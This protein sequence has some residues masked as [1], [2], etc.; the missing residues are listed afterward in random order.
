[1]SQTSSTRR[2][3]LKHSAVA[4]GTLAALQTSAVRGAYAAADNTIKIALIGCGG[5]GTGAVADCFN[6]AKIL[7]QPIKLVAV[8]DAFQD[9]AVS[10][11][12]YIKK[13]W[14]ANVDVPD[15]RIFVGL[16]GYQKALDCGID[17][18]LMAAPPG[19]RPQHYAEAV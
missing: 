9:R 10:S 5:R 11:L 17:M 6:A 14:A 13:D 4:A 15:D 12:G 19:V 3:F 8:A 1:M 2:D 7:Q 18:V 16:D